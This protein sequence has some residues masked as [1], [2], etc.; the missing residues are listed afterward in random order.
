[1]VGGNLKEMGWD[2]LRS[3]VLLPPFFLGVCVRVHESVWVPGVY[4]CV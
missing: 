1:M 3:Q 2:S 4:V